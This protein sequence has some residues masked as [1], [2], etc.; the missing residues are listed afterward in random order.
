MNHFLKLS[1]ELAN[2][3]NYL[4]QLLEYIQMSPDNIREIDSQK[5]YRF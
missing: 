4:D 3:R 1:I 2:Q 5:W